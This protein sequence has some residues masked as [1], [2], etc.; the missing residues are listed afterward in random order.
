MVYSHGEP[1]VEDGF[2]RV[3]VEVR[4]RNFYSLAHLNNM[5]FL[6]SMGDEC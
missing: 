3:R 6:L 1:G 5:N 4:L 2:G